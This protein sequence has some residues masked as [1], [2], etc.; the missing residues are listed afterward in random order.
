MKN[1]NRILLGVLVLFAFS[2]CESYLDEPKPTDSLT[3]D[4][5]YSSTEGVDAYLSGIY[6][7]M[8]AQYE[9]STDVA[10]TDVGGI[11]SM[12]FA[13]AVK[14]KDL[15]QNSWYNFDYE[16]DNREP[17]Y[18]RTRVT[19][20]FLFDLVNHANTLIQGVTNG[21]LSDAD[22]A[23][24]IAH[25]KALR[26]YFYFQLA[27][28]YQLSYAVDPSAPAPPLYDQVEYEA[29][30]MSTLAELYTLIVQDINDAIADLPEDRLNKSYINKSVAYGLKARILMAMNKDWDQVEAAANAA[31]GG[32][33]DAALYASEYGAG[34]DDINASE[35]MWGMD[36][37]ADQ[38][39]YYYVAPHAFTDHFADAYFGTY[40]DENFV[41]NFSGTDVRSL[42][43]NIYGGESGDWWEFVT[44]KFVFS[45]S[46]DIPIMRTPEMILMEA[47][48]MYHQGRETEAH[49]LLFTL[50]SDRDPYAV[51]SSATG[52]ALLEEILLE[53]R[54]EMYGELGVEWFDA[55][56]LQR[57][58]VRGANHRVVLTLDPNDKRFFLKIPQTEIDA[59]PNIDASVNDGR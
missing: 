33:P 40:I 7:N 52:T 25:G 26:A 55:K 51:Q 5:I 39:N 54:K 38:S 23:I 47:E 14:G 53:R 18:R 30:G 17:T 44:S 19:W 13:R 42:F 2:G 3:S 27:L 46:A 8:R 35:W 21:T 59:N 31:Y 36:Q 45:F 10:T 28:E 50:Q 56:R 15:I 12:Y 1:I 49:D 57:G 11:Y 9:Y 37:Q 20:Q 4:A 32:D 41:A 34:F 24:Y 16:N 29:K 6:R 58:I 22:K 48:A 43:F